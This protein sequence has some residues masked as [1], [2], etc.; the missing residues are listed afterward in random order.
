MDVRRLEAKDFFSIASI[1]GKIGKDTFSK[2]EEELTESQMGLLFITNA[3]KY[4]ETEFKQLF[5]SLTN[6]KPEDF[7]HLE[8][9][10]P[11][12]VLEKIA[13]Q[14]DLK[15]VFLRLKNLMNTFFTQ[16]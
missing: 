13:E 10:A 12:E 5:A 11:I 6:T 4:A 3:L 2:L 9:E 8:F 1:L 16:S 7:D 15:K 14:E